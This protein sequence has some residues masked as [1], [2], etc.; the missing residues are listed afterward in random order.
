MTSVQY[1]DDNLIDP[2]NLF[3]NYLPPSYSETQLH[4]LFKPFGDIVSAKV[5]VDPN[6]GLSLCYGFIRFSSPEQASLA[7]AKMN[8]LEVDGTNIAVRFSHSSKHKEEYSPKKTIF[9][10]NIDEKTSFDDIVAIFSPFGT[11]ECLKLDK[12]MYSLNHSHQIA[13]I[14]MSS[15]EEAQNSIDGLNGKKM[16]ECLIPMCI[17]FAKKELKTTMSG[18][19]RRGR[20]GADDDHLSDSTD[21]IVFTSNAPSP[22]SLSVLIDENSTN[23]RKS[24]VSAKRGRSSRKVRKI[25][26]FVPKSTSTGHTSSRDSLEVPSSPAAKS[27]RTARI[28]RLT[29]DPVKLTPLSAPPGLILSPIVRSEPT[30]KREPL[31]TPLRMAYPYP[32]GLGLSFSSLKTSPG[33]SKAVL[34][35]PGPAATKKAQAQ[36]TTAKKPQTLSYLF[37]AHPP[38]STLSNKPLSNS[39]IRLHPTSN[40]HSTQ[41]SEDPVFSSHSP[42]STLS[43]KSFS[44]SVLPAHHTISSLSGKPLTD[45]ISFHSP[46]STVSSTPLL[47]SVFPSPLGHFNTLDSYR[48][49]ST[50]HAPCMPTIPSFNS[51]PFTSS[52]SDLAPLQSKRTTTP[53]SL[54]W[55]DSF[56]ENDGLA[57]PRQLWMVEES[58]G[59]SASLTGILSNDHSDGW[60]DRV[61]EDLAESQTNLI[62]SF[63][64]YLTPTHAPDNGQEQ[65]PAKDVPTANLSHH[66]SLSSPSQLQF[67]SSRQTMMVADEQA[68]DRARI[69]SDTSQKETGGVQK[70][71]DMKQQLISDPADVATVSRFTDSPSMPPHLPSGRMSPISEQFDKQSNKRPAL[72]A[73]PSSSLNTD[74]SYPVSDSS[75]KKEVEDGTNTGGSTSPSF[76]HSSFSS[77]LSSSP[78]TSNSASSQ[79]DR[80]NTPLST[81]SLP[82]PAFLYSPFTMVDMGGT[83]MW[84]SGRDEGN[85]TQQKLISS[86][87]FNRTAVP[88]HSFTPSPHSK[89]SSATVPPLYLL[90]PSSATTTSSSP[91]DFHLIGDVRQI[92]TPSAAQLALP[93]THRSSH[94]SL[95]A[96]SLP[97][98]FSQRLSDAQEQRRFVA[99]GEHSGTTKERSPNLLLESGRH[100]GTHNY[101]SASGSINSYDVHNASLSKL[102]CLSTIRISVAVIINITSS[103]CLSDICWI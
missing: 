22:V 86:Y 71:P 20:R 46:I 70:R 33:A 4:N 25:I 35:T 51:S 41:I 84:Q 15:V 98:A 19:E 64:S 52:A 29:P 94:P 62:D 57:L 79:H 67:N 95:H 36:S 49:P 34:K 30:P 80:P 82:Q 39:M 42:L 56:L 18:W 6:T 78:M 17:A 8:G 92:N 5:Q 14:R 43:T 12:D 31:S 40:T 100:A 72:F 91:N 11:V 13:Y 73:S 90:S 9:V 77:H 24:H 55:D 88:S 38:I 2:L 60:M 63:K 69:E 44:D 1:D 89:G 81:A 26:D 102:F 75:T 96:G 48:K 7:V 27:Y 76:F 53:S 21:S 50:A 66:T 23:H 74:A 45:G 47:D 85:I 3:V 16:G 37:P 54:H 103:G 65:A 101:L 68:T 61:N 87:P 99:R 28:V 59:V 58:Q 97:R 10:R 93:N 83:V 32:P